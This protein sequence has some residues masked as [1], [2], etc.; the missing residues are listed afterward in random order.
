[1][2]VN[3]VLFRGHGL[4]SR[5]KGVQ[6]GGGTARSDTRIQNFY[7]FTSRGFDAALKAASSQPQAVKQNLSIHRK[8][9][10]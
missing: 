10:P 4:L 1:M 7:S 8:A 9:E 3:D 2:V 5:A 6:S